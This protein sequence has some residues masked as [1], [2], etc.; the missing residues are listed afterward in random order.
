[1]FK[2]GACRTVRHL[3]VIRYVPSLAGASSLTSPS[4]S[5]A[6]RLYISQTGLK[7]LIVSDL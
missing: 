3:V 4:S 7:T 1:M 2:V 6:K 5:P